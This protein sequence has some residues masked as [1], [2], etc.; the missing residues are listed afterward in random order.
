MNKHR[1]L[2]LLFAALFG[3][4]AYFGFGQAVEPTATNQMQEGNVWTTA[5]G[6][7]FFTCPVMGGEGL[8]EEAPAFSDVNG[9]RYYHCCGSCQKPFQS[10]P[11][12]WTK[13]FAVP[14]NVSSV[15]AAGK[16]FVDPVDSTK[17]I[18]KSKTAYHDVNGKRYFCASKKTMKRFQEDSQAIFRK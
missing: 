8:V 17:G 16:H 6:K 12:K 18:V 9:V 5:D 1:T 15:D 4:V 2:T 11:S 7:K 13:G 10:E 3:V 14:G